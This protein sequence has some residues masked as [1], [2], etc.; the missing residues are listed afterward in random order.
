MS[1]ELF[2]V[3]CSH[4]VLPKLQP[5]AVYIVTLSASTF[6]PIYS[7]TKLNVKRVGVMD[8]CIGTC[9]TF[10]TWLL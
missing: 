7:L 9:N 5:R 8:T 3:L 1:A 4:V 6:S 10:S 2:V